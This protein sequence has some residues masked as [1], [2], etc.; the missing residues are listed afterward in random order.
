MHNGDTNTCNCPHC[1]GGMGMDWRMMKAVRMLTAVIVIIFVF[2]CG[3]QL[4]EIKGTFGMN[5]GYG[6]MQMN[7]GFTTVGYDASPAMMVSGATAVPASSAGTVTIQGQ[8]AKM[9]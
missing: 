2:W 3:V 4:G 1:K 6:M 7:R 5:H 9:Q 8:A